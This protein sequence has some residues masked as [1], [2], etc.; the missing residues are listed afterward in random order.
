MCDET[1][2]VVSSWDEGEFAALESLTW[3]LYLLDEGFV[4]RRAPRVKDTYD[5]P[6]AAQSTLRPPTPSQEEGGGQILGIVTL[7]VPILRV[8]RVV[9][10][11]GRH[12]LLR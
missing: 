11:G 7:P 9:E 5:K 8:L 10:V 1:G 4:D 3:A 6:T 2:R 12:H